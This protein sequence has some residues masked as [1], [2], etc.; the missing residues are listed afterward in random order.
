VRRRIV[1]AT[2]TVAVVGILVLGVPLVFVAR[3]VVRDDELRR[4]DRE[5]AS[6]AFA[7]D[8]DLEH[9]RPIDRNLLNALAGS[10]RTIIVQPN[11]RPTVRGGEELTGR[12]LSGTVSVEQ[13]GHVTVLVSAAATDRRAAEAVLVIAALSA[14]GI[15]AAVGLALLVARRLSRPVGD[16]ARASHRLGAG[17]FSVRAPRSGVPE[18]DEVA[19][20][21]DHSAAR[22]DELV[23][24]ER[25][26]TS[27]ASHQLR[28]P[29]TA[30]RLHL[31]E[32]S[33]ASDPDVRAEAAAALEHADRL[34]ATISDLLAIAR[35]HGSLPALPIDVSALVA[36]RIGSWQA[37]ARRAYRI[38]EMHADERCI[39]PASEP[40]LE[41][42]LDAL[43]DNAIRHGGGTV[44]VT[45]R[46]HEHHV[47]VTVEDHGAGIPPS[48]VTSVFDRHV[49]LRGG[50]GVGLALAR[51]LVE[52]CG[53]RLELVRPQPATFRMILPTNAPAA[54][55]PA[56]PPPTPSATTPRA[57][58]GL[59]TYP[60][61]SV[62]QAP[63][64]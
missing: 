53:G 12:T 8:D 35:S 4:V 27:N 60:P 10:D 24:A 13:H 50:T 49:S 61:D 41:Q 36:R 43:L 51:T 18:V 57:T 52:A 2:V 6:V 17:D 11:G 54:T 19:D 34:G 31:E 46:G 9:Q 3:R 59:D 63:N 39:A 44:R 38:I 25:E 16:L 30:L 56:T 20:A 1:L 5:A 26:F 64:R 15:I 58:P 62:G 48:A 42:A 33:T 7:I 45:V 37:N 14:L 40:A 32:L 47:E 22:I 55:P 28:T 21:L 23:R 29:L